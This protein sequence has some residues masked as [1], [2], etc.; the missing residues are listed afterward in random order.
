MKNFWILTMALL[1]VG[2]SQ[3]H[4]NNKRT[5]KE[6]PLTEGVVLKIDEFWPLENP[7]T[8]LQQVNANYKDENKIFSVYL[9]KN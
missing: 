8:Y 1:F 9:T 2:C 7:G 6:L 5:I 3:G 4:I